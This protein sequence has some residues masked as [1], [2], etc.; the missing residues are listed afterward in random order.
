MRIL[1]RAPLSLTAPRA[2]AALTLALIFLAATGCD[3]DNLPRQIER[4][5]PMFAL[6]D[7][8]HSVD[9]NK[10]HGR[11]IILSFWATWC[12]PCLEE[13]PSLEALQRA[14]PQAQIV[15]IGSTED[16]TT[17]QSY[18]QQHPITVL[19]VFDN[20]QKSNA[21]Y[22]SFRFPETYVID[23]N[24]VIRRKFIGPQDWTSPA[25]LNYLRKLSA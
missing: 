16:F 7:G 4:P 2:A 13:M 5:A 19:S 20:D 21:L 12:A 23:K 8:Q 14:L 22:G 1:R 25:I 6:N 10:L 24:G 3:R 15:L 9:L 17:Y 18:L 11:V